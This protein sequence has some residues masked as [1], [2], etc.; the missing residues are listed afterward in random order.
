MKISLSHLML[1]YLEHQNY[2]HQFN[3]V[4]KI[5]SQSYNHYELCNLHGTFII[6][7]IENMKIQKK[8]SP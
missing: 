3:C 2:F 5:L 6:V 7:V 1:L 8:K 4:R